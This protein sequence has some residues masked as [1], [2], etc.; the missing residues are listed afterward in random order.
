MKGVLRLLLK[1][2]REIEVED[3]INSDEDIEKLINR[4]PAEFRDFV[5]DVTSFA[6]DDHYIGNLGYETEV[7]FK[8]K[9][10]KI[11]QITFAYK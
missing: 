11:Q 9:H 6:A 5:S 7:W 1:N 2:G 10:P 3:K 4:L 8:F